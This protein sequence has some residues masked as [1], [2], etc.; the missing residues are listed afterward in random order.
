MDPDE[1]SRALPEVD[2]VLKRHG[3]SGGVGVPGRSERPRPPEPTDPAHSTGASDESGPHDTR[4]PFGEPPQTPS[5]DQRPRRHQVGR[6]RVKTTPG[7][8]GDQECSGF[9]CCSGVDSG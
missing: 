5:S 3:H 4:R 9:S 7:A 2:D 1:R 8:R 6:P